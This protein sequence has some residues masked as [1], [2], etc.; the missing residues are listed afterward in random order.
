[1]PLDH[2]DGAGPRRRVPGAVPRETPTSER[3]RD[4]NYFRIVA[5]LNDRWR[6]IVCK[7]AIQWILQKSKSDGGHGRQWRG[8]KFL[9][10]RDALIE[11]CARLCGR[12]DPVAFS[13]LKRLPDHISH[14]RPKT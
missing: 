6:V 5:R 12:C 1:M 4:D 14:T 11:S 13:V 10:T 9:T 8:L 3:E 2:D 7:D